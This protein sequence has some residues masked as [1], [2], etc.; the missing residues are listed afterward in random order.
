MTAAEAI[1]Y[2]LAD[3]ESQLTAIHAGPGAIELLGWL[4]LPLDDAPALIVTSFHERFVPQSVTSDLFLPNALREKL[5]IDDN[6]R[7]YAR[8]AYALSTLIQS[9]EHVRLIVAR[10][11]VDGDPELPSRLLLAEVYGA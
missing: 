8:D 2:V 11:N 5:G 7:R 1:R 9:R 10:R 4:E 3:V 6:A